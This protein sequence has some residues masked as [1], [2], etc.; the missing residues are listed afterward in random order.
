MSN[1][2]FD[3]NPPSSNTPNS[4]EDIK[5]VAI[6]DEMKKSYLDYAMSVIVSRALP[7]I[8]D[9][10]KPVHRRIIYS[11]FESGFTHNKP[12]RK[13][14]RIVGDVMGKYHPHGDSAIYDALV[15][16]AQDFSLR[17]PLIDGQGNFGSMDGDGAAAMRYTEARMASSSHALIDDIDKD[18]VDFRPNYDD[19][20]NEPVVIPARYPN[21]LVNGASG[22]AVGMATNIPTHNLGELIDACLLLI[23][24][25][26]ATISE[27]MQFVL[28]PDF[29]TGAK[30]LGRKGIESAF[31]TGRGS[32]VICGVAEIEESKS[33]STIIIKEIPWQ[34]NKAK[35]VEE[36]S[37]I[38]DKSDSKELDVISAVRDESDRYGVRIVVDL[39][40]DAE[41]EIVLNYLQKYTSFQTSFGVNMLAIDNGVPKLLNLKDVLVAFIEFR[42]VVVRRRTLFLLQKARDKAHLLA[43]LGISVENIDEVIELIK[44]SPSPAVARERL[45]EKPWRAGSI[46]PYIELLDEPDRKVVDGMYYLSETQAR[47]ILD[48]RLHRLTGLEREK[49]QSDLEEL[50]AEIKGYLE[51]LSSIARLMEIIKEELAE[52]RSFATPRKTQIEEVFDEFSEKD[53]ILK[54]EVTLT[55]TNS[56]YIKRMPIT[57]YKTQKRGGKGKI[58][59]NTKEED[60]VTNILTTNSHADILFFTDK[61]LVYKLQCYRIPESSTQAFGRAII[62]LI[63]IEKNEKITA[64][65]PI[66]DTYD[67]DQDIIFITKSGNIRRSK[68]KDFSNVNSKGKIAMKLDAGDSLVEV[69]LCNDD[70]DILISSYLGQCVRFPLETLR[71]IGSRNSNGVRAIKLDDG[72]YVVN[73]SILQHE[74]IESIE[75]RDEYLKYAIAKRK[76]ERAEDDDSSKEEIAVNL[77]KDKILELEEKEEFILTV[78]SNGYGK[79]TSAYNYR[80]SNRGV[81]GV[82]GGKLSDKNGYIVASFVV[83]DDDE[84]II[85]SNKGQVIR[86][87]VKDIRITSRVSVGVILFRLDDDEVVQSVSKVKLIEE[88]EEKDNIE[89]SQKDLI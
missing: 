57:A 5:R 62:N 37:K 80:I 79:R 35:L 40:K 52:V 36:I 25:P 43:G 49:I 83:E 38:K 67:E 18:T 66:E 21:L 78:T 47:G 59:T 60:V 20:L 73:G 44:S 13:S 42:K 28:G 1:D 8:R 71:V 84:I 53:F 27:L 24:N 14:A 69:H 51:I 11:M 64:I 74:K 2:L 65:L 77:P 3:N 63:P 34:V 48:L 10:L 45:M 87:K 9:G 22:I 82:V 76:E 81:K 7:D 4:G 86:Q 85:I 72:D 19:S 15:R 88:V 54:E 29:P 30:I 89:D 70:Q 46:T 17:L 55:L 12:Y 75:I 39:K 50:A 41:P 23:D 6:Y 58:G 68:L 31:H 16:M 32:V 26:E 56:G 61:G 33:R